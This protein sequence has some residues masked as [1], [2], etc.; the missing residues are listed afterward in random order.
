M[1]IS[2]ETPTR[3]HDHCLRTRLGP[4][5]RRTANRF[6][7]QWRRS[8]RVL[9]AP[10]AHFLSVQRQ[11]GQDYYVQRA[12]NFPCH[13]ESHLSEI[14]SKQ[15]IFRPLRSK[16]QFTTKYTQFKTRLT[17]HLQFS[18]LRKSP[19][20][21]ANQLAHIHFQIQRSTAF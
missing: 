21:R 5:E 9:N 1:E 17:S 12:P 18:L 10:N 20:T 19:K 4:P 16:Y 8:T 13:H 6:W 14:L 15:P 7:R 3:A 11:L 2:S